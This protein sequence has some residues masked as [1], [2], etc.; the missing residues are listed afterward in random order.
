MLNGLER[1]LHW[2]D[3]SESTPPAVGYVIV[4]QACSPLLMDESVCRLNETV[5]RS[6][7]WDGRE[8]LTSAGHFP[9]RTVTHWMPYPELPP[10]KEMRRVFRNCSEA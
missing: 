5:C 8:F 9:I 4:A 3:A 1:T 6:A 10:A 2:R 7:Y